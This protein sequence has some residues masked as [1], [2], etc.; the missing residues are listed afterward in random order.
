MLEKV[1]GIFNWTRDALP[2]SVGTGEGQLMYALVAGFICLFPTCDNPWKLAA[3]VGMGA[4]VAAY[5]H[6]R[7]GFKA[8]VLDAQTNT[9][10]GIVGFNKED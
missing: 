1:A 8:A 10:G 4:V 9:P 5:A 2:G 6:A 7:T 3:V